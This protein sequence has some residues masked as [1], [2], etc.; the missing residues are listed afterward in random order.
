MIH[1]S[2][3]IIQ[4]IG[5]YL[6]FESQINLQ[7]TIKFSLTNMYITNK[8]SIKITDDILKK[9]IYLKK[10]NLYY[11]TQVTDIRFL[12]NLTTLNIGGK[13]KINIDRINCSKIKTLNITN[14]INITDLSRFEVLENLVMDGI[15]G[16]EIEEISK[17]KNLK[18]ISVVDNPIKKKLIEIE[19]KNINIQYFYIF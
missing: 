7:K 8:L 2:R 18:Y 16:V 11:N 4:Y 12:K 6:D 1:L 15:C 13:C 5:D 19:N 17:L 14:N 10:L 3:D 9:N